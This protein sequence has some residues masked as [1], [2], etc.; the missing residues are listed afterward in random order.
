MV[1]GRNWGGRGYR[2]VLPLQG[3]GAV[4]TDASSSETPPGPSGSD[5]QG[6]ALWVID[7]W[8]FLPPPQ[9]PQQ[10]NMYIQEPLL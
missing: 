8:L 10:G 3:L 6:L 5:A 4:T 7:S 1:T 9:D 2:A